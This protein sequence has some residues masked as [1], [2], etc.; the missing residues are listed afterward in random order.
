[1]PEPHLAGNLW[2]ERGLFERAVCFELG[3]APTRARRDAPGVKR[4]TWW[5]HPRHAWRRM[6]HRHG[7]KVAVCLI[8]LAVM[9]TMGLLIWFM[10]DI[11]FR[12]R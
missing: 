6:W 9:I 1:M 4:M 2:Q 8:V 3:L 10:S 5:S 12:G 7:L 11:R